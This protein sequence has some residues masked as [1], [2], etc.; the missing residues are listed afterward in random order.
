MQ[1][2]QF[3]IEINAPAN[4]VYNFMLGLD[5]LETYKKWTS[6]FNPTSTYVGTWEKGSKIHFLGTD[7][8][9]N[10]GGMV[11]EIAEN[12]PNSFVSIKHIGLLKDGI[13]VLEG[14]DVEKWAGGLENYSFNEVDQTT[15]LT[16]EVDTTDEYVSYFNETWVK[17]LQ[18]LKEMS[19]EID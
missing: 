7:S 15:H 4:K 13:E 11:S 14:P 17:A 9:G 8:E 19:E 6:A 12:I 10:T 2:L 18:I 5:D 3:K 1:K 16:I